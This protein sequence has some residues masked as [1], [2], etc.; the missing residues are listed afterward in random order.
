[1]HVGV[2]QQAYNAEP[3]YTPILVRV[4]FMLISAATTCTNSALLTSHKHTVLWARNTTL[5][6]A[7]TVVHVTV[8]HPI[9][10]LHVHAR[11]V[12]HKCSFKPGGVSQVYY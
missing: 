5:T 1:M 2:L 9:H 3:F 11:T 10:L 4:V 8:A 6:H 7:C 12:T